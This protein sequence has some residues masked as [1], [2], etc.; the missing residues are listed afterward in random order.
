MGVAL[1]A[2]GGVL[3]LIG[4]VGAIWLLV[5]AF[6]MSPLEGI[7]TLCVPCYAFYFAFA[8]LDSPYKGTIIGLWLGAGIP[9][10][11]LFNVGQMMMAGGTGM[12]GTY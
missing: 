1:M 12:K 4:L 5:E 2:I 10:S 8:K 7:L 6:K 9:G 11:I 3:S